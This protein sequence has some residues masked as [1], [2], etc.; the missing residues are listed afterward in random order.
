MKSIIILFLIYLI[1]VVVVKC[2][3][4][5]VLTWMGLERTNEN[6]TSDL[7]QI[8]SLTQ[9][10]DSVAF[11]RFNLGA[12]STLIVNNFTDV[13]YPLQRSGLKTLP[14]VST[15]CPFGRP[16]V[17]EYA[18]QLINNPQP[19]I[20]SAIQHAIDEG[21]DGW[22]IDIEPVGA[23]EQDSIGYAKFIDLFA[24][25]LHQHNK[26]LTV[27]AATWTPFWNLSLLAQTSVDKI[28]TMSTY[29]GTFQG[30]Q[31]A[32]QFA[33]QSIPLNKLAVGV[34][35]VDENNQPFSTQELTQRFQLLLN[36]NIKS[37]GIWSSPIPLNWLPFLK[38]FVSS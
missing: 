21:F 38:Q 22:N 33:I 35:T 34:M 13:Q 4:Q 28:Y 31:S 32:L 36:S 2:R 26:T 3:E 7:E 12:N 24:Q 30:F 14:M 15:C 9:I 27:C 1:V 19:F 10:L 17:I 29:A 5:S 6:I 18:R 23:D 16:E 25:Q 37:L 8:L 11:E 20:D